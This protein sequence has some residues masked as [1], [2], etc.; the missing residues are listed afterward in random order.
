MLGTENL[1]YGA[2]VCGRDLVLCASLASQSLEGDLDPEVGKEWLVEGGV[3]NR[4]KGIRRRCG[5]VPNWN[6]NNCRDGAG[7]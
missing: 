5:G 3:G 7:P 2:V 1:V 4:K 6:E